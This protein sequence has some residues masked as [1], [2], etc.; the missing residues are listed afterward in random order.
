MPDEKHQKTKFSPLRIFGRVLV[1]R[2]EEL[3]ITVIIMVLLMFFSAAVI[4][5]FEREAQPEAFSSVFSALWWAVA[6][7]TTVGYGDVYPITVGGKV[8]AA[9]IA[10]CG[11]GMFALPTG[12]LGSGFIEE[13][14]DVKK[15]E[16]D[17]LNSRLIND[18]FEVESLIRV[19]RF[20]KKLGIATPRKNI[21]F[22]TL[23]NELS[24]S[25]AEVFQAIK[26][27]KG[28]RVRNIH[29]EEQSKFEDM[30]V[31]EKF[32]C[33]KSYGALIHRS[34]RVTVINSTAGSEVAVGHF[35]EALAAALDA[36]YISNEYYSAGSL[37]KDHRHNFSS[38]GAYVDPTSECRAELAE[39][40]Q[41]IQRS[42]KKGSLVIVFFSAAKS[43]PDVT[44]ATGGKQ[45]EKC[46]QH[47]NSTFD[48][49]ERVEPFCRNLDARLKSEFQMALSDEIPIDDFD[50]KRI[51]QFIRRSTGADVLTLRVNIK[52]LRWA[53]NELY[54]R[55]IGTIADAIKSDLL[56]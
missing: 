48:D 43:R 3:Y 42:I 34:D 36:S 50:P 19:R 31:V 40:R 25:E 2:K 12:I 41:D 30:V 33:N 38:N 37:I 10:M 13:I 46:Y 16:K 27:T 49:L 14:E 20:K 15:L 7:L 24:L 39:F 8:F 55:F 29:S 45:G 51:C 23:Q 54:Y 44:L 1:N 52:T 6:A 17:I 22:I 47:D 28:L 9:F 4:H 11:I 32:P 26:N 35:S 53:D 21:E 56:E 5:L 18:A